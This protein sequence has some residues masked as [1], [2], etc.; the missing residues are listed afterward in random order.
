MSF[1]F[2]FIPTRSAAISIDYSIAF[3]GVNCGCERAEKKL[4]N[5]IEQ[6]MHTYLSNG[7][8]WCSFGTVFPAIVFFSMFRSP[9]DLF[10][11]NANFTN[12][13]W[14]VSRIK[15]DKKKFGE[16]FPF[17]LNFSFTNKFWNSISIDGPH[18][19]RT[20]FFFPILF[21]MPVDLL[22]LWHD[23]ILSTCYQFS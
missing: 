17:I 3:I 6:N 12:D 21:S 9:H 23:L 1:W 18:K 22:I 8:C 7:L 15:I 10:A 4:K 20:A 13:S 5:Y 11:T 16:R 14:L 19:Q 2:H